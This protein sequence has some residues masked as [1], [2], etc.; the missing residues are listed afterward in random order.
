MP[1]IEPRSPC[2]LVDDLVSSSVFTNP[3]ATQIVFKADNIIWIGRVG[4]IYWNPQLLRVCCGKHARTLTG[5]DGGRRPG[6]I[7]GR[8]MTRTFCR[9]RRGRGLTGGGSGR[10]LGGIYG[11]GMTRTLGWGGCRRSLRSQSGVVYLSC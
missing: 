4:V 1:V 7:C 11:R 10:G 2:I 6:G 9:G 3:T 8:G 5:G